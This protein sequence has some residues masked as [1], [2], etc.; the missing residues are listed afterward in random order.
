MTFLRPRFATRDKFLI[1]NSGN[2]YK[3]LM[4]RIQSNG[5]K[6]IDNIYTDRTSILEEVAHF[7]TTHTKRYAAA[8]PQLKF[9][10]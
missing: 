8:S 2:Q 7:I 10:I 9:T 4:Y 5:K 6:Y 1:P 3:T